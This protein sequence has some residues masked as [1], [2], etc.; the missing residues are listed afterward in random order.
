MIAI[1]DIDKYSDFMEHAYLN[2][3]HDPWFRKR[4]S[5]KV[6]AM[7]EITEKGGFGMYNAWWDDFIG[8]RCMAELHIRICKYTGKKK[9]HEATFVR[10]LK[11][12]VHHGLSIP[13]ECFSM[14]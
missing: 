9:I 7:I 12:K 8:I 6:Y 10:L 1:D 3:I 14:I 2:K 5:D 13:P 4:S 11:T